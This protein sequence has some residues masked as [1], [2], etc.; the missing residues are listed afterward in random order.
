MDVIGAID[1]YLEENESGYYLYT[2]AGESK[3][4]INMVFGESG[5]VAAYGDTAETVYTF[6]GESLTLVSNVYGEDY[7]LGVDGDSE[8]TAVYPCKVTGYGF[9]CMFYQVEIIEETPE[10]PAVL[11]LDLTDGANRTSYTTEQQ[12][13]EQNGIKLTNNKANSTVKV[14]DYTDPIR[15]YKGSEVT[16]ECAGMYAMRFTY[17]EADSR[18]AQYLY[19]SLLEVEGVAAYMDAEYREIL[20]FLPETTDSFAFTVTAGQ[21]RAGMLYVYTETESEG[22][23]ES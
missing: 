18:Y 22:P 12:I 5:I 4:Y 10:Y 9:C 15:L 8:D 16:I 13:W 11:A 7:Y 20:V 14:G 23:S 19:E 21:S 6:S 17:S 2:Y 3:A 1:V